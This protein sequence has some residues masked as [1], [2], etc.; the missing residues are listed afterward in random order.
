MVKIKKLLVLEAVLSFL[1][2]KA[3]S[4]YTMIFTKHFLRSKYSFSIGITIK[5]ELGPIKFILLNGVLGLREYI[6]ADLIA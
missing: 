3:C 5:I 1:I 2:K 4:D 6:W